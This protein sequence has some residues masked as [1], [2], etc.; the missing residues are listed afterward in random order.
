MDESSGAVGA[1]SEDEPGDETAKFLACGEPIA[2]ATLA[3]QEVVLIQV[4]GQIRVLDAATCSVI[5]TLV[6]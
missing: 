3:G 4:A 2:R 6:S 5:A 1:A